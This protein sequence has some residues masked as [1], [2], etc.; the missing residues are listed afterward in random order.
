MLNHPLHALKM[1]LQA[2]IMDI[3]RSL[4]AVRDKEI[5]VLQRLT[6]HSCFVRPG[7]PSKVVQFPGGKP[8]HFI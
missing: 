2:E 6:G 3:F 1:S 5:E 7:A 4:E 8:A